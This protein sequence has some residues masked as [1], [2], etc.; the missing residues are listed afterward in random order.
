MDAELKAKWVVTLRSGNYKQGSGQLRNGDNECCCLG[1]LC[2]I[3]D[4][5]G[6]T[7]GT[8][9]FWHRGERQMPA[10]N[11]MRTWGIQ[12]SVA[13]TLAAMNDDERRPFDDI[14]NYI[15]KHL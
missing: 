5:N 1:V 4:P 15:E 3:A 14:A 10:E 9:S 8:Q 13:R 12:G 2:D 7:D 6:W 11:I